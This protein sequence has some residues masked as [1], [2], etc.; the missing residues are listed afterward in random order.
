[1]SEPVYARFL[2]AIEDSL[3]E[4][5]SNAL[6]QSPV[7]LKEMISYHMGWQET[8][9]SKTAQGKRIRPVLVLLV[10]DACGKDWIHALPTAVAVEYLHNFSLIHDDIQDDSKQRHGRDTLWLR[11]GI[12]QAIN[13]GD[14]M[15]SL[16]YQ[17]LLNT[18]D[19]FPAIIVQDL[20][21]TF[22]DT[23]LKL[24]EGQHMDMYFEGQENIT[25]LEY[26]SMIADKTAALLGCC[27]GMGAIL[28]LMTL[29]Q[30]DL[31]KA[32]GVNLGLAFQIQD[33]ILGIWGEQAKTGKSSVSDL[34]SGKKTLP[35][36]HA[37]NHSS[38]FKIAWKI[39]H[40]SPQAIESL[41]GL[42]NQAESHIYAQSLVNT[43]TQNALSALNAAFLDNPP[44]ASDLAALAV[45]LINRDI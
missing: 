38:D 40:S 24:T 20:L 3:R 9:S 35:I 33:D 32:F 34:V 25:E 15:F 13:T 7:E 12:P 42:I 5:W 27:T 26:I 2:P 8:V 30:V 10:V 44:A 6:A 37:L 11:W 19:F 23:C 16:A 43:Y 29:K 14:A 21:S 4:H 41:M 36:L 45:H 18:S 39:D 17:A 1:M 22:A 28:G 31:L